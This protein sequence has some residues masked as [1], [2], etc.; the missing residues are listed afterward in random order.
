MKKLKKVLKKLTE[1]MAQQVEQQQAVLVELK[2]H[3]E[4]MAKSLALNMA[5][6]KPEKPAAPPAQLT[7]APKPKPAPKPK[8]LPAAKKP[9]VKKP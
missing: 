8:A 4:L 7:E 2:R 3:N 9:P 1:L 5:A 6:L